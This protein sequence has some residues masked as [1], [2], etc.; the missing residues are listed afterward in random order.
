[1]DLKPPHNRKRTIEIF[2]R[3]T[4]EQRLNR[5]FKLTERERQTLKRRLKAEHPEMDER[6]L[7]VVYADIW[8]EGLYSKVQQK[9]A[10]QS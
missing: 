1:M 10:A 2:R 7:F 4:P 3:M 5:A 8:T 6:Q 9:I